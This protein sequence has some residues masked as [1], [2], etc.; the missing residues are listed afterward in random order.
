MKARWLILA[1]DLT[2]AADAAIP[3][4]LHGLSTR[5]VWNET[6]ADRHGET[7]VLSFNTASRALA[8]A[9]AASI[10]R[11]ALHR[12]RQ[13]DTHLFKKI[14][15]TLRGHPAAEIY[16]LITTLQSQHESTFCILAP[17]FP[18]AGRT[19]QNARVYV[20]SKP[21][22]ETELWQRDHTYE[23][24]DL[25]AILES[26]NLRG[27]KVS[28]EMVRGELPRLQSEL[29]DIERSGSIAVCDAVMQE[30]LD[31][32]AQAA[33]QNDRNGFFVGSAG[34]TRALARECSSVKARHLRNDPI[35]DATKRGALIVVGSVAKASRHAARELA[36]NRGVVH[37]PI[38]HERLLID[39]GQEQSAAFVQRIIAAVE[40]GSDA[41]VEIMFD[42]VPDLSLTEQL[43]HAA[44]QMLEPVSSHISGIA[45]TGGETAAA[46]LTHFGSR[47]IRLYDE[48]EPGICLGVSI[49]KL[50]VPVITKAGAFGN[51]YSLIRCVERLRAI[52]ET[53]TIV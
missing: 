38:E 14:D 32:I 37:F 11:D 30:D 35:L 15:S 19:T 6:A 5:V 20:D 50:T 2:G 39:H 27:E 34:L 9:Q 44:G 48:L 43:T 33:L 24:A 51:E 29:R 45:A 22:E 4:A 53:G 36:R 3:F 13:H 1:D 16:A 31:R 8:G 23:N 46:L 42:G 40:Q 17:A 49:G 26:A 12:M 41:L 47:G 25:I 52:R 10:H 18:A 28:L 7:A 21:L